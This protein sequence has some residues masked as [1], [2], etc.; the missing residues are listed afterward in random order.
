V[1]DWIAE[2]VAVY[3]NYAL[4]KPKAADLKES[5]ERLERIGPQL[6]YLE[7]NLRLEGS[8]KLGVEDYTVIFQ[9]SRFPD[10]K[11]VPKVVREAAT[12]AYNNRLSVIFIKGDG[13]S[14]VEGGLYNEE[15]NVSG[16]YSL[17]SSALELDGGAMLLLGPGKWV[18][19]S[20]II[21]S[22]SNPQDRLYL[23]LN[24]IQG[25]YAATFFSV[26]NESHLMVLKFCPRAS[27]AC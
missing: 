21:L 15:I 5:F 8:K 9:A 4:N 7:N 25:R 3:V 13:V 23:E 20:R 14:Y 22:L 6:T 17:T 10:Q 16:R 12:D 26:P 11:V 19:V 1:K 18:A 27:H 2:S 24:G